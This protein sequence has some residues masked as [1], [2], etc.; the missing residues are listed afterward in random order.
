M[1]TRER[2]ISKYNC[3]KRSMNEDV[4]GRTNLKFLAVKKKIT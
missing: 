3:P 2:D 1:N 4:N